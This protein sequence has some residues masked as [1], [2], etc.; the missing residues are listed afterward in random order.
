MDAWSSAHMRRWITT[1]IEG[2]APRSVNWWLSVRWIAQLHVYDRTLPAEDR[3]EWAEAALS[4]TKCA[5]RF[6]GYDR[7]TAVADAFKLRSLLVR[8][9]GPVPGDGTW[10]VA[11]LLRDVL[12]V[13]TLAPDQA[14]EL[15]ER[16][17]T[18]PVEQIQLLRRHKN[19]LTPLVPLADRLPAGSDAERV[20]AWLAVRPDLP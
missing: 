15:A 11:A 3:R 5:E 19:L 17:Q 16:W 4:L 13:V 1:V 9:L 7:W 6:T 14:R 8:E 2:S 10:D 20:R 18:L 12:A